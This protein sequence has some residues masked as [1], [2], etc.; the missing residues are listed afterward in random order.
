MR[1]RIIPF[2]TLSAAE[3][4]A[5]DEMIVRSGTEPTL[6]FSRVLRPAVSV[7]R[8]QSL[9]LVLDGTID[10]GDIVMRPSGGN[11]VYHD[12]GDLIYS[13]CAPLSCFGTVRKAYDH[14]RT[15]IVE[16]LNA[17]EG[18]QVK[19]YGKNDIITADGRK[20]CGNAIFTER[21]NK[22]VLVHGSIFISSTPEKWA[23]ALKIPV[24]DRQAKMGMVREYIDHPK[25][26]E[27]IYASILQRACADPLITDNYSRP[28][29]TEEQAEITRLLSERYTNRSWT[30]GG[31]KQGTACAADI[32]DD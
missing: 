23:S 19:S 2:Q 12:V 9:D 7:G 26:V 16:G 20:I 10:K 28:H 22:Y 15:W 14:V 6:R 24:K 17:L 3:S 5:T 27:R 18:L 4:M 8:G 30:S 21:K 11:A 13:V 29:S 32:R 31:H 1:W 25:L